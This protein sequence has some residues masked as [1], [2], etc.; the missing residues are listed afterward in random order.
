MKMF[1]SIVV[2]KAD[3]NNHPW[4]A[5]RI[6]PCGTDLYNSSNKAFSSLP[7]KKLNKKGYFAKQVSLFPKTFKF[8][9][10]CKEHFQLVGIMVISPSL[11]LHQLLECK[12]LWLFFFF[13][14]FVDSHS[15]LSCI[16]TYS[17]TFFQCKNTVTI[18]F[19]FYFYA[20]LLFSY[21]QFFCF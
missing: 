20:K 8:Q 6:R 13:N 17:I 18:S 9:I 16:N 7:L 3:A 19:Y 4:T 14:T 10:P 2:L 21:H 12:T 15:A 5:N 1:S 11:S